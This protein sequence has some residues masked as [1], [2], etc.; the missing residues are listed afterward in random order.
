M[1]YTLR[2]IISIV[3]ILFIILFGYYFLFA[4]QQGQYIPKGWEDFDC[5]HPVSISSD[6]LQPTLKRGSILILNQCI[7]N[8][9]TLEKGY[10]VS[11]NIDGIKKI[12]IIE[13]IQFTNRK[14]TYTV[15]TDFDKTQVYEVSSID[16]LAYTSLD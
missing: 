10:I 11:F 14:A 2:N 8:V 12:G 1:N 13:D 6:S 5:M 9:D 7:N 15:Y 4:R 3:L 16:I